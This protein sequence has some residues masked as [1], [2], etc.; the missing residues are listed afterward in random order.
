MSACAEQSERFLCDEPACALHVPVPAG[1][2]GCWAEI[3][4]KGERVTVTWSEVGSRRYCSRCAAVR[5]GI[6]REAAEVQE[7]PAATAAVAAVS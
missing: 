2:V 5:L 7:A 3:E 1:A 6:T 4:I